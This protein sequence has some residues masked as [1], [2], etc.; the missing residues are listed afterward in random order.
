MFPFGGI[1][2]LSYG[3]MMKEINKLDLQFD[4]AQ[5]SLL[6]FGAGCIAGGIATTVTYPMDLIRT[7]I[8]ASMKGD[9]GN[10]VDY[11]SCFRSMNGFRN[12]YSG[13]WPTLFAMSLF[14]GLQQSSYDYL[15]LYMTSPDKMNMKPS[16][17]LFI[18]CSMGAAVFSQTIVYPLDVVRRRM[19]I[20]DQSVVVRN[21]VPG[22]GTL[23]NTTIVAHRTWFALRNVVQLQGFRSLFAGVIPT[24]AKVIPSV[25]VSVTIRDIMLGRLE[26]D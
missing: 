3:S 5:S 17:N 11:K 18:G 13:L 22:T 21:I 19:Q 2:C 26:S 20:R 15:R 24:Y 1:V 23:H 25:A 14:V 12:L 4:D 7:Q 10:I 6:R 8:T 9:G 16:V